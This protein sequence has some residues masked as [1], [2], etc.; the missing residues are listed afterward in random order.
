[1]LELEI[2]L[3]DGKAGRGPAKAGR[4]PAKAFRG[5]Q[6]RLSGRCHQVIRL[7]YTL[8]DQTGLPDLVLPLASQ[9]VTSAGLSFLSHKWE[10]G[11]T[12]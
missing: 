5:W 2:G 11:W 10:S 4:G 7:I 3:Q 1:M 6:R 9:L 12:Q 8:C